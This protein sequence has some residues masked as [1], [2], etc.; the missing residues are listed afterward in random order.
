[1]RDV[2]RQG[3]LREGA[4]LGDRDERLHLDQFHA[5]SLADGGG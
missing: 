5:I 1:L 3:R 2:Q 4:D